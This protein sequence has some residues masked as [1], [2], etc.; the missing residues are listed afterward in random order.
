MF[1]AVTIG[2]GVRRVMASLTPDEI[3]DEVPS[4]W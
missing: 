1:T 2:A 3:R 4:D